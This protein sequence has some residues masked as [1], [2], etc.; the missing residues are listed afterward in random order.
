M[1]GRAALTGPGF[2]AR[3]RPRCAASRSRPSRRC[4]EQKQ[5]LLDHYRLVCE[6]FGAEKGTILMRKSPV[7]MP[8][9][10]PVPGPS[11]PRLATW[12]R[13]RNF[14]RGGRVLSGVRIRQSAFPRNWFEPPAISH[15]GSRGASTLRPLSGQSSN[16]GRVP[17][18]ARRVNCSGPHRYPRPFG[19]DLQAG[20][21]AFVFMPASA[22]LVARIGSTPGPSTS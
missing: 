5:L 21:F 12:R 4:A 11:A 9:A 20:H 18:L 19:R 6:Q 13:E 16:G 7:A 15:F 3:P 22:Y 1:I 10:A 8:R 14:C 2:S 17:E